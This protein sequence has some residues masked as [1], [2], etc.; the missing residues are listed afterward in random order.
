MFALLIFFAIDNIM[1]W[2][3]S[4]FILYPIVFIA[5]GI[6]LMYSMGLGGV[7][8]PVARQTVNMALRRYNINF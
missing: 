8:G 4:P 2:L 1:N 3:S 6:A 7:M 5:M